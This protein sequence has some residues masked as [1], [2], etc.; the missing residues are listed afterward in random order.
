M[1]DAIRERLPTKIK[2]I[3]PKRR[4]KYDAS[5]VLIIVYVR[6]DLLLYNIICFMCF[7]VCF[8][9]IPPSKRVVKK[10]KIERNCQNIKKK[11]KRYFI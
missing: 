5:A 1:Y 9:E 3:R 7:F 10:L 2:P 4:K 8:D 11:K 6:V